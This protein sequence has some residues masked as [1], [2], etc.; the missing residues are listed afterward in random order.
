MI[1][2]TRYILTS[3]KKLHIEHQLQT[4]S[5]GKTNI[6]GMFLYSFYIVNFFQLDRLIRKIQLSS[7]P[8]PT[9]LLKFAK[10]DPIG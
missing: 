8:N 9:D 1:H 4:H 5:Y 3:Q 6:P 7:P 10:A 2:Y